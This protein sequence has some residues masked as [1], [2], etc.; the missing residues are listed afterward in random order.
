MGESAV[1]SGIWD[2]AFEKL[3]R[4]GVVVICGGQYYFVGLFFV[5]SSLAIAVLVGVRWDWSSNV[6]FPTL[7]DFFHV[8]AFSKDSDFS[9]RVPIWWDYDLVSVDHVVF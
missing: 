4:S 3:E 1:F 2:G 9:P 6:D 5:G 7:A 8:K